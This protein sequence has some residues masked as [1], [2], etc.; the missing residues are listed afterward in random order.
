MRNTGFKKPKMSK[1]FIDKIEV[2]DVIKNDYIGEKDYYK[3][4][5]HILIGDNI[6]TFT[7]TQINS[8]P[9]FE[10]G[11]YVAFRHYPLKGSS[12]E[13]I[14][15]KSFAKAFTPEEIQAFSNINIAEVKKPT[16]SNKKKESVRSTM[17]CR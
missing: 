8:E 7:L 14:E 1:G 10:E 16:E 6:K 13:K 12:I 17:K 4:T 5:L 15:A 9:K 11:T 3:H 2:S